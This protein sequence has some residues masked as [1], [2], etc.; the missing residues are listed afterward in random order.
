MYRTMINLIF[1]CVAL[2]T[3][4]TICTAQQ[5]WLLQGENDDWKRFNKESD[6]KKAATESQPLET[7]VIN[8]TATSIRIVYDV[9]GESGDWRDIDRYL[10]QS[11]GRLIRLERTFASTAQDIKL[12]QVFELDAS[13]KLKKISESEVSLNTGMAKKEALEK[14]QLPIAT[15]IKQ[16]DFIKALK[17]GEYQESDFAEKKKQISHAQARTIVLTYL[18][19][20]GYKTQSSKF[21]LENESDSR[22]YPDFYMFHA[23]YNT[24]TR[25]NSIGAYA[26]NR[27]NADLWERLLCQ[28]LESKPL[29]E[30][31]NKLCREMG[32]SKLDGKSANPCF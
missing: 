16:L 15:N 24:A 18:K 5:I 13:G 28:L 21:G 30:L 32:L 25:L 20:Q 27:K 4:C 17:R 9:Q 19:S 29:W 8:T 1:A 14:P 31:Q 6:W 7:A 22:E 23:Y 12:S 2:V 11:N 10:F 26:V 3:F